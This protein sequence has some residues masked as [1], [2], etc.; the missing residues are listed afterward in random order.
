MA[1]SGVK[2]KTDAEKAVGGD[3]ETEENHSGVTSFPL[4]VG[5]E[6]D[7]NV[8]AQSHWARPL[9]VLWGLGEAEGKMAGTV[10]TRTG[11][12]SFGDVEGDVTCHPTRFHGRSC[13]RVVPDGWGVW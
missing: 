7:D 1:H 10:P 6:V 11:R 12:G 5:L 8:H 2:V 4:W 13:V 3:G 9:E